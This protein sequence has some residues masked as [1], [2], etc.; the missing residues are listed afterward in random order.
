MGGASGLAFMGLF[1]F[2]I[3]IAVGIFVLVMLYRM[4]QSLKRIADRLDE[5]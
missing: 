2:I 3:P 1:T 4:N 5:K